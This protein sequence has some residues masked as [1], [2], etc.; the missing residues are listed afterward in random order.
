VGLPPRC[1]RQRIRPVGR[2]GKAGRLE[3]WDNPWDK[4]DPTYKALSVEGLTS[5]TRTR[6]YLRRGG[7]TGRRTG[8]KILGL[9]RGVRV[10]FPSPAINYDDLAYF[11]DWP[12]RANRNALRAR[13]A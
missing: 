11:V 5:D 9:E 1:D 4:I 2:R 8:L 3:R 13:F 7:E 12:T 10:R 6:C